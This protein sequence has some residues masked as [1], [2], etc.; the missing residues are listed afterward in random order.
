MKKI[1]ILHILNTGSYSGAENVVISIIEH[2][3]EYANSVYAGREGSIKGILEKKGIDYY[4]LDNLDIKNIRK[5]IRKIHP[6]IIHAHD[7][8]AGIVTSFSTFSIPIISHLHNNSPWLKTICLKS[9][10]YG[11]SCIKYK[12]ILTVSDSIMKEY[13]FGK[14]LRKKTKIV[15]NPVD[16]HTICKKADKASYVDS[17]D[18]VFLGRLSFAK[19]PFYFLEII[20][21][22]VQEFPHISVA[23][24]GQ[25]ELTEEIKQKIENQGLQNTI[26]CLGFLDN[27]YGILKASKILCIPSLWEGY[28]L[29]AIEALALGIPVVSSDV[30]G[31]IDIVDDSCGKRCKLIE[32]YIVEIQKL[33]ADCDY[34]KNKRAGAFTKAK[35]LDNT[36][37]FH[38]NIKKIYFTM[39]KNKRKRRDVLCR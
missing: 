22:C 19:N 20:N 4:K 36:D 31:L 39:I 18:I 29:A 12:T 11:F 26:K 1:K 5:A 17:Y 24:I 32:E 13:I 33:L 9:F 21:K 27:P 10:I 23:M 34:Y 8:T 25:G 15:G 3:N 6:D 28:G 2:S 30:G 35:K 16:I 14:Q 38:E 7:F 37:S